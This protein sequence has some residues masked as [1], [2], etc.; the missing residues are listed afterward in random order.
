MKDRYQY[1][2]VMVRFYDAVY[3]NMT[4]LAD[5]EYYINKMMNTGGPVLEIGCGTGRLFCEALKREAD[6]YGIDQSEL[7]LN[8]LKEKIDSKEH[9][10]VQLADAKEFISVQKYKLIIAPFRMFQHIIITED[11]LKILRNVK[12]NLETGG[13]FI[14]D[15]FNPDINIIG[16]GYQ[17]TL[18]S[19]TE[20]KPGRIIR[21]YHKAKPDLLNQCI[22]V[23]FRF[24]W[25]EDT[26]EDA[27]C[28][29]QNISFL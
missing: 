15:V 29:D 4:S 16:K 11:Q 25:Q 23:T 18:Q 17:E 10:R 1:P 27:K 9:F 5:K 3:D 24:E 21:R 26:I 6:V 20:Y 22:N 19:E 14:F 2:E 8:K 12:E 28:L 13:I 7:M